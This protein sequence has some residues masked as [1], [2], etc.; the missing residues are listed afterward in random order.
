MLSVPPCRFC[1]K[2]LRTMQGLRGHEQLAHG[3][4]TTPAQAAIRQK[5]AL[6]AQDARALATE[7]VTLQQ[8][9][10]GLIETLAQV[11]EVLDAFGEVKRRANATYHER[12][13]SSAP[14]HSEGTSRV[15]ERGG[16]RAILVDPRPAASTATRK[17]EVDLPEVAP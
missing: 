13:G 6:R 11:N 12:G 1:G 16:A 8:H 4:P 9:L 15:G 17:F 2:R 3:P 7:G 14:L 10:G 5:I